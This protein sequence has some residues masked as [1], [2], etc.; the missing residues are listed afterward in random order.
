MVEIPAQELNR[1]FV[2]LFGL[3]TLVLYRVNE[4]NDILGGRNDDLIIRIQRY[5]QSVQ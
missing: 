3:S 2:F 5:R 1:G 4:W